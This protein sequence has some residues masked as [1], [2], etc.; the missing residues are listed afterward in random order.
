M[1]KRVR[2]QSRLPQEAVKP[3]LFETFE[4][5]FL[6]VLVYTIQGIILHC[7]KVQWHWDDLRE[8]HLPFLQF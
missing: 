8:L 4:T 1:V 7:L 3:L 2:L 5:E 6:K